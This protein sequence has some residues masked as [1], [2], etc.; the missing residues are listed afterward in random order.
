MSAGD[1]AS[2]QMKGEKIQE[3]DSS[4]DSKIGRQ[5]D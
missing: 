5:I 2:R 1:T 4:V 3:E